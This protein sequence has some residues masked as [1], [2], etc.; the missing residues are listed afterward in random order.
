MHRTA[1]CNV[2]VYATVVPFSCRKREP[3]FHANRLGF[4][5]RLGPGVGLGPCAHAN[6]LGFSA[7][8]LC[9]AELTPTMRARVGA[10]DS[11]GELG[12]VR[13]GEGIV[14]YECMNT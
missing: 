2:R 5:L 7:S 8:L 13:V 11:E 6:C 9:L 14:I 1:F 10:R 12:L 4:G 3:Y